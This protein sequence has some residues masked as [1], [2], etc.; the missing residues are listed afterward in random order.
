MNNIGECWPEQEIFFVWA[1][2]HKDELNRLA[3]PAI[4]ELLDAIS[5][6]RI[7]VLKEID[8]LKACIYAVVASLVNKD[9]GSALT[10]AR[11]GMYGGNVN[12]ALDCA[13]PERHRRKEKGGGEE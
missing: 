13:D 12:N 11:V 3:H 10:L 8:R 9:A 5:R 6:P 1:E 2:K 4:L 7:D